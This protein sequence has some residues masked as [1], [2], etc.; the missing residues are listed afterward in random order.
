[1]K[2][3]S[4]WAPWAWAIIYAGKDIENRTWMP[5][6]SVIGQRVLIHAS[7]RGRTW[8]AMV[9]DAQP[10]INIVA[11]IGGSYPRLSASDLMYMRGHIIGSVEIAEAVTSSASPWF[12]GPI[13]FVLRDPRPLS[14]IVPCKGRLGF[15]E[16]S[17]VA[18]EADTGQP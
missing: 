17:G 5:P 3:L 6:A 12:F 18:T 2:A 9:E 4:L 13:G 15:F 16:V 1:M 14:P 11:R 7:M 10:M 8:Q